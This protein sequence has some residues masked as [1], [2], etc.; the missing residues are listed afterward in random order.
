MICVPGS[1]NLGSEYGV[2]T[3]YPKDL[4]KAAIYCD[5]FHRISNRHKWCQTDR[6]NSSWFDFRIK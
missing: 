6:A 4:A 5:M 2:R 1:D 3:S